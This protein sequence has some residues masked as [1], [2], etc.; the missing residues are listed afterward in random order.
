[1]G[2]TWETLL[3]RG[4]ARLSEHSSVQPGFV[5]LS[6]HS[7]WQTF[8]NCDFFIETPNFKPYIHTIHLAVIQYIEDTIH[9]NK[10]ATN[11]I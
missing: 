7:S 1:M 11:S 9:G 4:L 3:E 2:Q 5:R 8:Q 10:I 6:E